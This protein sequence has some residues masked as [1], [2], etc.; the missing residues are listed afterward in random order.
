[1]GA[2]SVRLLVLEH[3]ADAP[4]GLL[5]DWARE[6][7]HELALTRVSEAGEFPAAQAG[8][9]LVS[10]GAD[11]SLAL[12][13]A[14]W[15]D[16]EL[17]CLRAAHDAG[18]PVLGICFG[19]QALAAALGGEVRRAPRVAIEWSDV[20][21]VDPALIEPGPWFRW[22][23]DVFTVPSGARTLAHVDG[24]PMAFAS[25][26]ALALQFHPEVTWRIAED[27][28]AGAGRQL[29]AEALDVHALR[30]RIAAGLPGTRERAFE[31]FDGLLARW[32][33]DGLL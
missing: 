27:W 30:E 2:V 19:G 18:R 10:L 22:H 7:G 16:A 4:A 6:R 33:A 1:V 29:A 8:E 12:R 25:R 31:L 32:R 28:I 9:V 13:N 17:E 11:T 24:V 3:Q 21:S 23:E 5:A 20:E 15:I 14:P 26:G